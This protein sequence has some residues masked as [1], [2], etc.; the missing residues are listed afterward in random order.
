MSDKPRIGISMGDPAGIGPECIA[1]S[2]ATGDVYE[3]CFPVVVGS[4]AVMERAMK[5]VGSPQTVR[6]VDS[7]ATAG[8]DRRV[9]DVLDPGT[10]GLE[11]VVTGQARAACGRATHEWRQLV[12]QLLKE[13]RLQGA[14]FASVNNEALKLAGVSSGAPDNPHALN[15]NG[16]LRV[17]R[18]TDH[19]PFR[20]VPSK[21]KKEA[22]LE[23]L[24][25]VQD[26]FERWGFPELRIAVSG[27]NPHAEGEEEDREI[28]PAVEEARARGMNVVGPM[29]PD[30]VFR[31]CADGQYDLVVAMTH[32]H[33]NIA[34][35]TRRLEGTVAISDPSDPRVRVGVA[36]GSAYDIAGKGVASHE[37]ILEAIKVAACFAAGKGL[38]RD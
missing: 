33:G 21:V 15:F 18:L 20:D 11:E 32:D 30:T 25:K 17:V 22:L 24:T 19:T 16:P 3:L 2:L 28:R 27:L 14:V 4:A 26:A 6:K 5:I 13:E 1:K 35:K 7:V 31:A 8:E 9:V 29:P 23:L 12:N 36:H 10:L 34:Q 37:S 38:P